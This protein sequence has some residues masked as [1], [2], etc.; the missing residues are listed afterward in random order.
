MSESVERG[1][2]FT[3]TVDAYVA[4]MVLAV[5]KLATLSDTNHGSWRVVLS[6]RSGGYPD[7]HTMT[8]D[9]TVYS[10][11]VYGKGEPNECD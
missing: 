7:K 4:S 8:L 10:A 1:I 9:A 6:V 5:E 11:T 2:V 3:K